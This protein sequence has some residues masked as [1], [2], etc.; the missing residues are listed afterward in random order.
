MQHHISESNLFLAKVLP[1]LHH[2]IG[3]SLF[4]AE[5]YSYMLLF[6]YDCRVVLPWQF[7]LRHMIGCGLFSCR[8]II[9]MHHH[10]IVS[11][12]F[13]AEMLLLH[14]IIGPSLILAEVYSYMLL[15]V[16]DPLV[17]LRLAIHFSY[18]HIRPL[19]LIDCLVVDVCLYLRSISLL[20]NR[21][22]LPTFGNFFRWIAE[23]GQVCTSA[24]DATSVV[25]QYTLK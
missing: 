21:F 20:T 17:V 18:I 4:L 2:I 8:S 6:A 7:I 23:R 12:L 25:K 22:A 1:V 5:A 16:H 24:C 15:F 10:A 9:E 19:S 14:H 13:L 3:S 11:S